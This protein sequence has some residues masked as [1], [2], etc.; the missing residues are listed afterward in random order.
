MYYVLFSILSSCSIDPHWFLVPC[1]ISAIMGGFPAILLTSFCY[2]ADTTDS[3]NR[4]G[5]LGILDFV[6]FGG[7]LVGYLVGPDIFKQFGYSAVFASSAL[8]CVLGLL[9]SHFLLRET[10]CPDIRVSNTSL[11]FVD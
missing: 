8:G 9:Y 4:A 6:L 3:E 2:I 10:I 7:Q 11:K 1:T 5:R